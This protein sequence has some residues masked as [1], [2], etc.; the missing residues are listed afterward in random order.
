MSESEHEPGQAA[1]PS[2]RRRD[3][4]DAIRPDTE[5]SPGRTLPPDDDTDKE[6]PDAPR[7]DAPPGSGTQR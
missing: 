6:R 5:E 3:Q 7:P 2:V 1:R 4:P